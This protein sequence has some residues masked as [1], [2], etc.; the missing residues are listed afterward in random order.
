MLVVAQSFGAIGITVGV[1][2]ASLLARDLSGSEA[3]AG[4]VQ[5]AQTLGAALFA[6][7][8][9]RV[10]AVRGRRVGQ[11]SGLVLGAGGALLAVAAGA[12]GSM[13]LLLLGAVLIGATTAA[14][15]AARYAATDLASAEHRARDLST[16]VWATTVGAVVGPNLTGPA[17][18]LARQFDLPALTGPFLVGGVLMVVAAVVVW[19]GMRPDPLLTAQAL[20]RS[21]EAAD[22]PA[23]AHPSGAWQV[24]VADRALLAAV[25]AQAGAHAAMVAVM[26][27]T[28]L[29]MEHGD[30]SLDVI[31]FVISIH[32]LGMFGFSPLVGR[33]SDR[34]GRGVVM[35]LGGVI[36]VASLL[37]S[38]TAGPG[39]SISITGGLFLL[40]LGWSLSTVA[41][42]ATLADRAPLPMRTQVQG[43][44][45]MVM[46]LAAGGAGALSGP[47]VEQWGYA[48]L[49]GASIALATVVVL[50]GLVLRATRPS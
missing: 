40:G 2:T 30:A 9:A 17:G 10:M 50:A 8:L 39:M 36:L 34:W 41:A 19:A 37:W 24:I 48:T 45:D 44:A 42:A 27:M 11:V 5:S 1:A 12:V 7:L 6:L 43:H 33:A 18:G 31:G 47:V 15:A 4:F 20:A 28:P 16:V 46:L 21:Q 14:N 32:V 23:A 25:L 29:H 3:Q 35:T 13:A 49:A 22:A 26:I 38:A